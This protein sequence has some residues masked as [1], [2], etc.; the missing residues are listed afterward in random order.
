M[1]AFRVV[2]EHGRPYVI[3]RQLAELDALDETNG[4]E[5]DHGLIDFLHWHRMR[6]RAH[7]LRSVEYC[8]DIIG[9]MQKAIH[10]SK[11]LDTLANE[12]HEL[13]VDLREFHSM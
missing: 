3:K 9:L 6:Q 5:M 8:E 4:L 13:K 11:Q 7:A 2:L 12:I 1:M 10:G